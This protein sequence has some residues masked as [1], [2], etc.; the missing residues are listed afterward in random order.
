MAT[1]PLMGAMASLPAAFAAAG[2]L[3]KEIKRRKNNKDAIKKL[4]A[5][6]NAATKADAIAK[7]QKS[8][9]SAAQKFKDRYGK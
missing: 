8:T 3:T 2:L 1:G 4:I 5:E 9:K 7:I 6:S